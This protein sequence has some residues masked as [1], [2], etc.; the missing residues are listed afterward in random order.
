[1]S[2]EWKK[3]CTD[4]IADVTS[5]LAWVLAEQ[6]ENAHL[7]T[8]AR[9][10][11]NFL[12]DIELQVCEYMA[13]TTDRPPSHRTILEAVSKALLERPAPIE[14]DVPPSPE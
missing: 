6:Y 13:S 10:T 7:K 11:I 9:D 12:T 1:M 2:D 4:R 14:G 3:T 8:N 5:A